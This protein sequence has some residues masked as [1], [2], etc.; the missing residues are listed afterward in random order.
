M[1][2]KCPPLTRNIEGVAEAL[3]WRDGA[4]RDTCDAIHPVRVPLVDTVPVDTGAV[5]G[6]LVVDDNADEITRICLN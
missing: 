6:E 1:V 3:A 4:L 2:P 5:L